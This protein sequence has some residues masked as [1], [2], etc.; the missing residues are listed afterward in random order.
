MT[1]KTRAK[2]Y[3]TVVKTREFLANQGFDTDT[4]EKT[5]KFSKVKDFMGV[6]DLIALKSGEILFVQCKT[7]KPATKK[8]LQD[9]VDKYDSKAACF[10]WYDN[11][12]F[13]IEYYSKNNVINKV[14]LRKNNN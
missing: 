12:G 11:Q 13:I 4:V 8:P 10:T 6:I 3:R 2:G 14:D 5:S 7:N 9:F 1:C